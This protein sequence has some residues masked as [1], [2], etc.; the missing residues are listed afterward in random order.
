MTLVYPDLFRASV[1]HIVPYAIG[2]SHEPDN[3]QLAHLWCNL[4]KSK[5]ADFT[6]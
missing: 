2:G 3:L 5:R 1:D 6:I 4:V